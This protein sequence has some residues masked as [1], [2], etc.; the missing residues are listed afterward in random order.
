MC[1]Y[2]MKMDLNKKIMV[3]AGEASGDMHGSSLIGAVKKISPS[4]GFF[5]IG[6]DRMIAEGVHTVHHV[7]DMSFL[8]FFAFPFG[9]ELEALGCCCS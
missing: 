1:R 9:R 3:I 7:N 8:G 2:K 4:I 5:G 6:G